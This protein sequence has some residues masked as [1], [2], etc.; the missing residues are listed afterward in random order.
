MAQCPRLLGIKMYKRRLP[1]AAQIK[2]D[3]LTTAVEHSS[4]QI[5]KPPR[6]K[7][8]ARK[9]RRRLKS[10]RLRQQPGIPQLKVRG[11]RCTFQAFIYKRLPPQS[12]VSKLKTCYCRLKNARKPSKAADLG[13]SS[14]SDVP[15]D[16]KN[17]PGK[18]KG[19]HSEKP[20]RVSNVQA[21][22]RRSKKPGL[23]EKKRYQTVSE[24]QFVCPGKAVFHCTKESM[25]QRLRS[26]YLGKAYQK[27]QKPKHSLVRKSRCRRGINNT[28]RGNARAKAQCPVGSDFPKNVNPRIPPQGISNLTYQISKLML[29]S[30][31]SLPSMPAENQYLTHRQHQPALEN[32]SLLAAEDLRM[33]SSIPARQGGKEGWNVNLDYNLESHRQGSMKNALV[34]FAYS[35][36]PPRPRP[37]SAREC[38]TK[39]WH[40]LFGGEEKPNKE[41]SEK[42]DATESVLELSASSKAAII[43]TRSAII[44]PTITQYSSDESLTT[45]VP[46]LNGTPF[47]TEM[48]QDRSSSADCGQIASGKEWLM[49]NLA[50]HFYKDRRQADYFPVPGNRRFESWGTDAW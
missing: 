2:E 39:A 13:Q 50:H 24:Y 6:K 41:V 7:K 43:Q 12:Q 49:G 8:Q 38:Y 18:E 35:K 25:K 32:T 20:G 5:I 14:S 29:A 34:S 36:N 15:T 23:M 11:R 33:L 31:E 17:L 3:N 26:I 9:R 27:P 45:E 30:P 10:W 4:A 21:K 22:Q 42:G 40:H 46:C 19:E 37:M 1:K 48:K 47:L 44:I 16:G 28:R